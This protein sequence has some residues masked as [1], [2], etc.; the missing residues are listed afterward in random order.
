MRDTVKS[1]KEGSRLDGTESKHFPPISTYLRRLCICAASNLLG[2]FDLF[3]RR[4]DLNNLVAGID[5]FRQGGA[6]L[7]WFLKI[8]WDEDDGFKYPDE[9]THIEKL[10]YLCWG[11]P[12]ARALCVQLR[13]YVLPVE[14]GQK[15]NKVLWGEDT[16]PVAWLWELLFLSLYINTT[17]LHA[18]L[19][20]PERM[21]IVNDFN[22][23]DHPLCCLIA[24]Y[25]VSIQGT[26]FHKACCRVVIVTPANSAPIEMQF[27]GRVIRVSPLFC[28][29]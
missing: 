29:Q 9:M 8:V 22:D 4:Y 16:V 15:N 27:W 13:D 6:N 20:N 24:M 19:T 11:Y 23:P 26:N 5:K 25:G 12:K 1:R 10:Q 17:A 28:T 2:R 7:D 3:L 18:Q 21:K 14:F